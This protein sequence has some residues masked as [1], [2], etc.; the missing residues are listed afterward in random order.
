M[1]IEYISE[2]VDEIALEK[3][4]DFESFNY[5]SVKQ[6]A[7]LGAIEQYQNI[8]NSENLSDC[9]KETSLLAIFSYLVMENTMLWI[10]VKR[11][12]SN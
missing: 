7:I 11:A 12:K 5:D 10:E 8:I 1:K 9:D 3:P 4:I 6:V 2:L